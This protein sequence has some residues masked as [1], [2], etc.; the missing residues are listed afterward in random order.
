VSRPWTPAD[1][2]V[3][4]ERYG[5]EPTPA[6]AARLDRTET[7]V[8]Q[9]AHKLRAVAVRPQMRWTPAIDAR[10]RTMNA[11]GLPD[12]QIAT[13]LGCDRGTVRDRRRVLGLPSNQ[14]GPH[15]RNALSRK[16]AEQ[17]KRA[18]LKAMGELRVKVWGDRA[19]KLGLPR[20]LNPTACKI[21]L[22]LAAGPKTRRELVAALGQTWKTANAGRNNLTYGGPHGS[23]PAWLRALGLVEYR[24]PLPGPGGKRGRQPSVYRLTPAAVARLRAAGVKVA[25]VCNRPGCLRAAKTKGMCQAC[26]NLAVYHRKKSDPE[27]YANYIAKQKAAEERRAELKALADLQRIAQSLEDRL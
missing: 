6:L 15:H 17:L 20:E 21:M 2:E 16:A 27:W 11:A 10:L 25:P 22:A 26:Y 7:A 9:L 24:V 23:Y 4:Q 1:R 12:G 19:E 13:A 5:R 3:V 14:H 18:G 8:R